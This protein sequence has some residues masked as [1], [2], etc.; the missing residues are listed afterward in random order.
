MCMRPLEE[1]KIRNV[2][3]TIEGFNYNN[4]NN[5]RV[6]GMRENEVKTMASIIDCDWFEWRESE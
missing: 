6:N 4:N 5:N 2:S 3:S 1:R